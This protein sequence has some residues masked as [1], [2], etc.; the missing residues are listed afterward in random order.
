MGLLSSF[1]IAEEGAVP[2]Y[3]SLNF[4]AEDHCEFKYITTLEAANMLAVLR[5]ENDPIKLLSKFKLLTAQEAEEWTQSVPQE[6]VNKLA[7]IQKE[8]VENIAKSFAEATKEELGWT[9][10]DF[11]PVVCGLSK[12]ARRALETKKAMYLWN[13]L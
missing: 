8:E 9:R 7:A 6:M 4:C 3:D 1:F 10:E 12:L 2:E 5:G 13:S 11:K